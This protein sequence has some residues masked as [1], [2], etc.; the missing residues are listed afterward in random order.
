MGE[1]PRV[2]IVEDDES[3]VRLARHALTARGFDVD[4]ASNGEVGLARARAIKPDV[5]VSDIMMPKVD[6]LEFVTTLRADPAFALVPV[7]FLTALS[8]TQDRLKGFRLGADDYLPKPFH[9]E[10]LAIRVANAAKHRIR[11]RHTLK[12]RAEFLERKA[13]ESAAEA[14]SVVEGGDDEPGL[15][16][17]LE[18][19]GLSALLSVFAIDGKSGLLVVRRADS[20]G[21]MIIRDGRVVS[22]T[23]EGAQSASGREAVLTILGWNTGTFEY[24]A[25]TV[26]SEDEI[27]LTTTQ[28]LVEAARRIRAG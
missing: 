1:R 13:A 4:V 3:I 10:E 22:A 26:E 17:S 16:G 23:L 18:Q 9:I 28:L 11:L 24:D 27:G 8:S 19:L 2:L 12:L 21:R 25:L 15:R 14:K 20:T 6:G 7:I 5:I